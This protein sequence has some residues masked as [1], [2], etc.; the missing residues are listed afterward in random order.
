MKSKAKNKTVLCVLVALMPLLLGEVSLLPAQEGETSEKSQAEKVSTPGGELWILDK[1]G[2]QQV[3]C[4]LAHTDVQADIAGFISRVRVRQT[5]RNPLSRKIEAVY[6]FPLPNDSAVD[7]MTMTV[8]NRRIK[9]QIKPRE[10]ARK[11]YEDAKAKGHVASLLD[12]ERPNIFS[13]AVANIEPGAEVVIEIAYTETLKWKDGVYEW[14]FPTVVGPRY[15]PGEATGKDGVGWSPDTTRVPDASKISPSTLRPTM[16]SGHDIS[17][18][19]PADRVEHYLSPQLTAAID[20]VA[21][22]PTT[23]PHG[24]IIPHDR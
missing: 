22:N 4:P 19:V 24:K 23:D 16:R 17:L 18:Q 20:A 5:F 12:Q 9:G 11:T 3:A 10:E 2:K 8:G 14:V 13:Q 6:V 15:M 1:A 7:E 21:G